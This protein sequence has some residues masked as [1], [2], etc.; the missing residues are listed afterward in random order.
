[1]PWERK[2]TP[3]K[4]IRHPGIQSQRI[5]KSGLGPVEAGTVNPINTKQSKN[6]INQLIARFA[7]MPCFI[8]FGPPDYCSRHHASFPVP[9]YGDSSKTAPL[10][11]SY[12]CRCK[13]AVFRVCSK[14]SVCGAAPDDETIL[15][16][17]IRKAGS[18]TRLSRF[19]RG[20]GGFDRRDVLAHS[21]GAWL[22][23]SVICFG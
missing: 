23:R 12:C 1:M 20:S 6:P 22:I 2:Y 17:L 13:N 5:E 21:W 4:I 7:S 19:F 16:V 9:S 10:L 8:L 14:A 15:V 11:S 3:A 18:Q